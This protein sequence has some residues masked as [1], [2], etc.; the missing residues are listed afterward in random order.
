M[1][2]LSGLVGQDSRRIA[3]AVDVDI[4]IDGLRDIAF[5]YGPAADSRAVYL[6]ETTQWWCIGRGGDGGRGRYRCLGIWCRLADK[7]QITAVKQYEEVLMTAC[8]EA[9]QGSIIG[10]GASV[11]AP[12][13]TQPKSTAIIS[14]G[15]VNGILAVQEFLIAAH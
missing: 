9:F 1:H 5:V 12:Q 3:D 4:D 2:I 8:R 7:R 6:I 10:R 15:N 11:P 13:M 14:T